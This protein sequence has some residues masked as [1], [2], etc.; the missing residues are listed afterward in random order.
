MRT[1][2]SNPFDA[3]GRLPSAPL[4]LAFVAV[5]AIGLGALGVWAE[6]KTTAEGAAHVRG[7]LVAQGYA[8]PRVEAMRKGGCGRVR[9]LYAW[10][11]A[12]GSGT[13]CAGPGARVEIRAGG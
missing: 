5:V 3:I 2:R 12:E 9:R 10:R 1:Y 6:R 11:A 8:D 7:A 4:A 13:A